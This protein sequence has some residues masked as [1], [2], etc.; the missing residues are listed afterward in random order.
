MYGW[1]RGSAGP[2]DC[3]CCCARLPVSR[4][5]VDSILREK[6]SWQGNLASETRDGDEI[7]ISCR[8]TMNDEGNAVLEVGRD[9][10]A[11]SMLKKRC[12]KLKSWPPWAAWPASSPTR[13]TTPWPPSPISFTC[14]ATTPR[15]MRKRAA[16]RKW[17]S[18][19][20]SASATS[21]ARRSASIANPNSPSP[22]YYPNCSKCARP[23]GPRLAYQPHR[24]A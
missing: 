12:A 14:C 21:P 6:R 11:H 5:E 20:C 19:N 8:K 23:A 22:W 10:T 2:Q 7:I 17:P 18:R 24:A 9:L 16:A 4:E 13:S 1:K 15:W 3:T